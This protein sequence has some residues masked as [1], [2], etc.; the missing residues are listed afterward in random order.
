MM[1][2]SHCKTGPPKTYLL[3]RTARLFILGTA[4]TVDGLHHPGGLEQV[5]L[6]FI[7]GGA[8]GNTKQSAWGAL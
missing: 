5:M 7:S 6:W 1:L 3:T 2:F 8:I 4:N